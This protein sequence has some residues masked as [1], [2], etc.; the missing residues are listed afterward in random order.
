MPSVTLRL[1]G[2]GSDSTTAQVSA[3][4][5]GAGLTA[6][7]IRNLTA[8]VQ[9]YINDVGGVSST[10]KYGLSSDIINNGANNFGPGFGR[11]GDGRLI[12]AYSV[13][14]GSGINAKIVSQTSSDNGATWSAAADIVTPSS[15]RNLDYTRI[16]VLSNGSIL[17]SY[18]DQ[19]NN[20]SGNTTKIIV[21]VHGV[22][23]P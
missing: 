8:R 18:V 20:G 2:D 5:I 12:A 15:G 7:D 13:G 6:A 3:A 19:A 14:D 11:L 21:T 17:L 4:S 9:N 23:K 16:A 1:V 22:D 10:V